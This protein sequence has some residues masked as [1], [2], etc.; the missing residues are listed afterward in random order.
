MSVKKF[1][2]LGFKPK[3]SYEEIDKILSRAFDDI[4]KRVNAVIAKREKHLLKDVKITTSR[5]CNEK[6]K[7]DRHD[8]EKNDRDKNKKDKK[9]H[10]RSSSSESS[11]SSDD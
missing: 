5:M 8:R 9:K 4:R 11:S 6:D 10:H 1:K 7:R 2:R 3:M